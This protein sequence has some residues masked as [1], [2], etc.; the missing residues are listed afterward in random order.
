MSRW[1]LSLDPSVIQGGTH[2]DIHRG[3]QAAFAVTIG[4]PIWVPARAQSPAQGAARAQSPAQGA[5]RAQVPEVAAVR[6]EGSSYDVVARVTAAT[7]A[8]W[9]LDC[10][11]LV[12]CEG[13][14]PPG[15]DVDHWLTG[16]AHLGVSAQRPHPAGGAAAPVYT[17]FIERIHH[18]STDDVGLPDLGLFGGPE[19]PG[20]E[21]LAFTDA[22]RDD[23]GRADYLLDCLL[24]DEAVL[25]PGGFPGGFEVD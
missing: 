24:V 20:W 23:G 22:W 11:L 6:V 8:S 2:A 19:E 5:A 12:G 18:R 21:E 16:R 14:P 9:V 4:S 13:P 3:Q 1:H 25:H 10:G 15:I 7:D 17:W